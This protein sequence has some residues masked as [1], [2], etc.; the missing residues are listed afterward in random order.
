MKYLAI[1]PHLFAKDTIPTIV[2]ADGSAGGAAATIYTTPAG[3]TAWITG[4]TVNVSHRGGGTYYGYV[5]VYDD[6]PT[7]L[8]RW[9]FNGNVEAISLLHIPFVPPY[10][11]EAGYYFDVWTSNANLVINATVYGFIP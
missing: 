11:L 3:L 4:L 8:G 2:L 7:L 1:A 6:T 9:L 5:R 10:K